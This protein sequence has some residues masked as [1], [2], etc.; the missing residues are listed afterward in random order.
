MTRIRLGS[1]EI[2]YITMFEAI[3]GANV[4]DCIQADDTMGFLIEQGYMGLAI[5][6]SGN[7]I[8]RVSKSI[9]KKNILVMEFSDDPV[10]LVKNLF[11]PVKIRQVIIHDST[12]SKVAMIEVSKKDRMKVL[13]YNGNRI[14]IAKELVGRHCGFSDIIVKTI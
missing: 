5:G 3:T 8:K 9:G 1:D 12:D 6:K 13:G 10:S 11:Q 4:K 14:K 2:K 7:T